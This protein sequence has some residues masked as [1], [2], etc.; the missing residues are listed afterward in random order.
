MIEGK[1]LGG[2]KVNR[3]N[4]SLSNEFNR[5]LNRLATACNMRP[6]TL[7]GLLVERCLDSAEVIVELQKQYCLHSAYKIMPVKRNGEL[8]YLLNDNGRE[9]VW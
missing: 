3:V 2:K 8:S 1:G 9:D 6:T 4:V 5:K 7:A